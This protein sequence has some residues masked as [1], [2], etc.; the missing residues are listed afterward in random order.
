M[1]KVSVLIKVTCIWFLLWS[2]FLASAL[3]GVISYNLKLGCV[4]EGVSVFLVNFSVQ[5]I[6]KRQTSLSS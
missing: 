1:I 4:Q 6:Y 2:G 5:L 3:A